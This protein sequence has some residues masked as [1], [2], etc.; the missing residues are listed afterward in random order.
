MLLVAEILNKNSTWK[1]FGCTPWLSAFTFPPALCRL[2]LLPMNFQLRFSEFIEIKNLHCNLWLFL[3]PRRIC[4]AIW[5]FNLMGHHPALSDTDAKSAWGYSASTNQQNN[6]AFDK[7]WH[8][9]SLRR[10]GTRELIILRWSRQ[11]KHCP[12]RKPLSR[13]KGRGFCSHHIQRDKRAVSKERQDTWQKM[14]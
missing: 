14:E 1:D 2:P 12:K 4:S 7:N 9:S 8:G 3:N 13:Q 6:T 10:M 5:I 11:L